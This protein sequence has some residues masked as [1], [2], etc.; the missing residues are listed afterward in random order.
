MRAVLAVVGILVLVVVVLIAL[1]M[2]NLDV[3]GGR[4]PTVTAETGSLAVGESNTTVRVP[5]VE[6]REKQVA[7]PTLDVRPAPSASATPAP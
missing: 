2:V 5:S 6:M 1:G 7:V 4:L 3:S